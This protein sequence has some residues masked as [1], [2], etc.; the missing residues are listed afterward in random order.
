M[1]FEQYLGSQPFDVAIAPDGAAWVTNSGGLLAEFPSSVARFTFEGGVLRRTMLRFLGQGLKGVAID[2]QGNA[3]IASLDDGFVYGL[4]PDGSPIGRFA[5][6]GIDG[7]WDVTIDGDDN[8][9]ITSFGQTARANVFTGR[10]AKLCGID[11]SACPPGSRT[12]DPVT[13]ATGYTLP[14][15]GS[16]VLL[17]D[18]SPLYGPNAPPSYIPM[19]RQTGTVIDPAGNVWGVNNW[20][21][22]FD[23]DATVNPGGD[24]IVIFVG[25]APPPR[26]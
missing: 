11:R 18:G 15:A 12:G 3:W 8:L 10:L 6:G 5:G 9:W 25:L 7:P 1:R 2:S 21:P 4:R 19:M 17:H 24:G 16:Q 20:K 14:S 23:V 13:P 26:R 22:D